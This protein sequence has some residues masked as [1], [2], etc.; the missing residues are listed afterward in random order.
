MTQVFL[1]VVFFSVLFMGCFSSDTEK[2]VFPEQNQPRPPLIEVNAQT[3]R[4]T[5]TLAQPIIYTLSALYDPVIKVQLP[6]VGSQ[7]AGLRIVDF[8]E[9][10]PKEIDHYLEFK[11]WYKLRAD[12]VGTYIIPSMIVSF[13]D[14]DT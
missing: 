8:G 9:E 12:I 4:T 13:K 11:K 1:S 10:G 6:E 5:A 3:D 2:D 14:K 7:I